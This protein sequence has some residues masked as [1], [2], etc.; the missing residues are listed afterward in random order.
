MDEG[1]GT[2]KIDREYFSR[3]VSEG[4]FVARQVQVLGRIDIPDNYLDHVGFTVGDDVVVLLED[5]AIRIKDKE[6]HLE[7]QKR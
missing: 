6:E 7:D 1:S 5:G 4:D 2:G 3:Q